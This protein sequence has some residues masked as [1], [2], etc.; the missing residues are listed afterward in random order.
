MKHRIDKAVV[1]GA[2]TMGSRIAAHLANAG[3]PCILLDIVPPALPSNAP[4]SE[5]NKIVRAGLDAAKKSRPAAFFTAALADRIA[6]GNFE[7]DLSRVAEADWIMEAVA[8]NLEI[9]RNLLQRVA[10]F[11]KPEAIVTTNTSGLP[12]HLIAEGMNEEFQR[13]FAGTHFFN[14][15]RY[16]KLVELIPGPKTSPDVLETL[17]EFCDRRLGKGVVLAKDTPNFIANR[18]GTFSMLNALRQMNA[19]AMTVEEV[20]ACTGPAVG[21]PKSATF[22]TA[23]LVGIDVL[24]HVVRNIYET[25]PNDESREIYRVPPLIEEMLKRG[26]LGDKAGQGFYKKLKSDGEKEILTLDTNTMEYRPRQKAKFASLEMAKT[27]DDTRE[28]LRALAGPVLQGQ[29][30]DKAQQFLWRGLSETCL[31]AARR[32]PEISDHIADVDRAMRYGFAWEL[33]PFEMMD[34]IGVKAFAA[35]VKKEGRALPPVIEKMLASGRDAFYESA[36]GATTVFDLVRGSEKVEEPDGVIL[37]KSL[38]EAGREVERNPG[39]SLIDLGDGV[40]CVEFHSKMNAIG[41]DLIAMIHKGLKRLESDFDALVVA[42]QAANFSV[43]A[44]LMLVLVAAQEQE[45][46]DLHLAVKQFQNVNLA[47]KYAPKPVVVA[48]QGMALGGG[49]ELNLHGARI[50]AAAEAYLGL[51]EAGVGLIPG[52]GG[53]KE[54]L[55]RANEHAASG[56]DLDL[57]HA[58]KPVFETIAMAKVGTS[59]EESRELGFLRREDRV[60]MNRDRVVADAKEAAL[61][62]A[63]AGYRPRA[64]SW[65]E[66]A[67]TTQIK[68]L[69]EQFLAGA[70][71]AIHMMVRGGYASEYD[72]HVARKLAYVLAGGPLSSPQLVSE[73]Y[74]LD[75][76]REAFVSLCGEKKTQE[77]IAHTLKTGKPLRN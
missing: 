12:V 29:N 15:P 7:D 36:K 5:R 65:Q 53:S 71:L 32:I 51:V 35:Q 26:W 40:A 9:K 41:A 38:K 61:A 11:R 68:V 70:K 19:L 14:P 17:T 24:A 67:Q 47:I 55:I 1:L 3:V 60:T 75:L 8:E 6:I 28:R 18:I 34:A 57:F 27:I 37:L 42:N 69:G 10:Q 45:W 52:G 20:D 74:V 4:A 73:Q 59:A 56:E 31:Y 13:H 63:R 58:L 43:G 30:G 64:A 44:N 21:W 39:A 46:D 54:M 23:D 66:A 22:R 62:L 77:R 16:L 76:E 2:G 48:P 49:C 25:A 50:Q 33:G 72:A